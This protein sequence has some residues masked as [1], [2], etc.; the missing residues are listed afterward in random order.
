MNDL[1]MADLSC[2]VGETLEGREGEPFGAPIVPPLE[3]FESVPDWADPRVMAHV[4]MCGEERGRFWTMI[5]EEDIPYMV[6]FEDV[7]APVAA[8]SSYYM[9]ERM[10]NPLVVVGSDGN[11]VEI[12]AGPIG[13]S[14]SP[15]SLDTE[16]ALWEWH[17]REWGTAARERV[18][19]RAR[20][21]TTELNGRTVVVA[22]GAVM[23][24]VTW[25]E[26][27]N[28]LNS[29]VSPEFMA[30]LDDDDNPVAIEWVTQTLVFQ[31]N[32]RTSLSTDERIDKARRGSLRRVNQKAL[33]GA[34]KE[35]TMDKLDDVVEAIR[36][37]TLDLVEINK[38][39]GGQPCAPCQKAAETADVAAEQDGLEAQLAAVTA[40]RDALLADAFES[41]DVNLSPL[42][43]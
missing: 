31:G 6:A 39:C 17:D 26:A 25:A 18:M 34:R 1:K 33:I 15:T 5:G 37:G 32:T 12:A 8:A 4:V 42:E 2:L 7:E 3:W 13:F 30:I 14:H 28:I 40:E 22:S 24:D 38:A 10:E 11:E 35:K 20:L 36:A 21:W 27:L 16:Q 19:A 41:I 23:A 43:V 29:E 9:N